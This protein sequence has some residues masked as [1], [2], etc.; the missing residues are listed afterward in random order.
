MT[1]KPARRLSI[2]LLTVSICLFT[3]VALGAEPS[4]QP[5]LAPFSAE[6][7]RA[8]QEAWAKHLAV[9]LEQKNSLGSTLVLIPPGEFSMGSTP[10]QAEA[11]LNLLKTVPRAAPG[12]ADR[13][14]KEEQPH[15]RVV[16]TRPFRMGRTE[17]TIGEYR[18]FIDATKYETETELFGG[19]NSSKEAETDPVKRK[20]LWYSPGYQVTDQS[21][22]TQLTWNDMI[23]FCNWLSKRERLDPCYVLSEQKVWTR[24]ANANGCRLPTEAEWEYAC[25][26]GTTTQY[27]FGDNVADLDEHAWFNRTA[28]KGREI[29]ARPVASKRPNPFGLYDMHGNAWERCED[30][31]AANWYAK[32]PPKDP[33]GPAT[34]VNRVV[35]GAGWHYFDLHC[36]SAY[37]NNYSPIGRTG[38]TG[39]R[40][41][42]GL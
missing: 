6:Q 13:I 27:S 3:V 12:E 18:Q 17:V 37:R 26:A 15:H 10:E 39:F 41:V 5:A 9:P 33:Q 32:S 4:P 2:L 38:N 16:L 28:E 25:R 35:R 34:G 14:S 22:V 36:R 19:G 29:G 31:H 40:V 24:I 8:Y 7:A 11:A 20:A 30:Y 21:P 42:C 1:I 23:A